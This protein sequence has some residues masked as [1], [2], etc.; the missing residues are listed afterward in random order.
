MFNE[1]VL[2]NEPVEFIY[3]GG[4][5]P[6][7]PRTVNVSLVFQLEEER[8]VYVTAIFRERGRIGF[9][10]WIWSW[11]YVLGIDG[12]KGAICKK[13]QQWACVPNST[14]Y[15]GGR[16]NGVSLSPA[17]YQWLSLPE[18]PSTGIC[19]I[20]SGP[21]TTLAGAGAAYTGVPSSFV[22]FSRPT[23]T[24]GLPWGSTGMV[25]VPLSAGSFSGTEGA[26][27]RPNP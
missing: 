3:V 8:R 10:R 18:I 11:F 25:T 19:A 24:A 1:G 14:T 6:G 16:A 5:E 4:S 13:V 15:P 22:L 7:S 26:P 27:S 21:S 2:E 9:L 23:V 17:Q 20:F 12:V